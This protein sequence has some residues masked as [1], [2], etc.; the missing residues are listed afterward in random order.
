MMRKLMKLDR[1]C[2]PLHDGDGFIEGYSMELK[3][4]SIAIVGRYNVPC[5]G[6]D[7][8]TG[9]LEVQRRVK[10]FANYH[11]YVLFEGATV[12]MNFRSYQEFLQVNG[13]YTFAIIDASAEQCIRNI[14]KRR[15]A[16]GNKNT[17]HEF[18]ESN[19]RNKHAYIQLIKAR[20]E[21][22][23]IPHLMLPYKAALETLLLKLEEV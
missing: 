11:D 3:S 16:R 20:C 21:A 18:D 19:V 14:I 2:R 6:C 22:E 8:I 4:K 23:G 17:A 1:N 13:R 12:S 9:K 5:G 7:T 15:A 10:L